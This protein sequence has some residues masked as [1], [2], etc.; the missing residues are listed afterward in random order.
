MK[1]LISNKPYLWALLP[2]IL[3][4]FSV[5]NSVCD[6]NEKTAADRLTIVTD[7]SWE[8][9]RAQTEFGAYPL[10]KEAVLAANAGLKGGNAPAVVARCMGSSTLIEGAKPIWLTA[11]ASNNWETRQLKKVFMMRNNLINVATLRVNCDD[12]ARVYI[13]GQLVAKDLNREL[14]TGTFNATNFKQLSA[15]H[16]EQIYAYDIKSFLKAGALNTILIE[17]ASEPYN[18]GHAYANARLDVDFIEKTI[19]LIADNKAI[20]DQP[21]KPVIK[22]EKKPVIVPKKPIK[23]LEKS[24]E[25]P[26]LAIIKPIDNQLVTPSEKSEPIVFKNSN[27]INVSKLKIGDVFELGNIYFKTD[28]AHLNDDSQT[29]LIELSALLKANNTMK[30]EIGGHTNLIAESGYAKSLSSERAK[31]VKDFLILQG[32]LSENLKYKGYG[33][34]QPKIDEKNAEA[35]RRNQR[36]EVKILAK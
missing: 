7:E 5:T 20:V 8:V 33:K 30:I 23:T 11:R 19:A 21:K 16:Y 18:N 2:L 25:K 1:N 29:T 28:D 26:P 6:V 3:M 22:V 34:S 12:A 9:S 15:F 14:S 35:N 24:E 10:S 17:V 36:V 27:D 13:N 32:A 31:S 4:A